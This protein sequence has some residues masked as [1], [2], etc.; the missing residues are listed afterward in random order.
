MLDVDRK[1][2]RVPKDLRRWLGARDPVC[3]FAGCTRAAKDCQI[4]HRLEWQYGGST[5]DTN[6]APLCE[7]HHVIKTKSNWELYRDPATGASWWVSPT[8][9]TVEPDPPPW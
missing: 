9:L 5:A 6:L 1:T 7:P 3:I 8:A 4:D 2:Y